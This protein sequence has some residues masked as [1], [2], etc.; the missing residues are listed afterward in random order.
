MTSNSFIIALGSGVR[1]APFLSRPRCLIFY[2]M[3]MQNRVARVM[4]FALALCRGSWQRSSNSEEEDGNLGPHCATR[5]PDIPQTG[6][7]H[8][9]SVINIFT[10]L[11]VYTW[12]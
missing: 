1:K 8:R 5:F 12:A 6:D 2:Q 4:L 3:Q 11:K 10:L 9:V 7:P